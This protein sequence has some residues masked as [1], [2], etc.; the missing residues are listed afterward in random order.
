MDEGVGV[1]S[2]G[3]LH[4]KVQELLVSEGVVQVGDEPTL[5]LLEDLLLQFDVH[6]QFLHEDG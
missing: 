3:P 4:H 6:C 2:L 1:A 5:G